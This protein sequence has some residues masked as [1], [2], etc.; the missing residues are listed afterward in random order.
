MNTSSPEYDKRAEELANNAWRKI[1]EFNVKRVIAPSP[2]PRDGVL[3]HYTTAEGLK[4]IIEQNE[5]WATSAYFLND[6]AEIMYGYGVLKEVLDDWLRNHPVDD[7][8]ISG[9]LARDLRKSFGEDLLERN[10]IHPI[11]LACFCEDDNLLS[12]WRAY[13][14]SGG[15]SLGFGVP[16]D[17]RF[18]GQGLMS[19]PNIY[20]APWV[21]VEYDRLEQTKRCNIILDSLVPIY[22]NP[23]ISRAI[24]SIGD[25]PLYGYASILKIITDL[26]LDEAASFKDKAFDVEK[27]WRLAVRRRELSKQGTDDGGRTAV[28]VH[29]RTSNGMLVP[30][31]KIVPTVRSEKLP[32]TCV[33]S[34]P[35]LEKAT[36]RMAVSMMLEKNGFLNTRVQGSDITEKFQSR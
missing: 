26:L 15:Y 35:M 29:F 17:Y 11:Y 7:C 20:T 27:E 4:G 28:P 10:I 21:K 12:Q 34:G 36:A 2:L 33:R 16:A 24:I 1:L 14:K 13:G 23:D 32:I 31:V 22:D 25:H 9:A 30:Y 5:L 3:Y 8:S 19:E 6:S 18:K